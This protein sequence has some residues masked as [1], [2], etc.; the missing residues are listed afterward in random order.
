M[1]VFLEVNKGGISFY[2]TQ[3]YYQKTA[4]P[5]RVV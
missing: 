2:L 4:H 1:I 3:N 5:R